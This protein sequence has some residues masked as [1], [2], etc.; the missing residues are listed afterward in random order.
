MYIQHTSYS[1]PCFNYRTITQLGIGK[2]KGG[3]NNTFEIQA[4]SCSRS[5]LRLRRQHLSLKGW[6]V[7]EDVYYMLSILTIPVV[8][9]IYYK[10]YLPNVLV[11]NNDFIYQFIRT[12]SHL[13]VF[14]VV[15]ELY[16]IKYTHND[17][18][19]KHWLHM[20]TK[21]KQLLL[22]FIIAKT[23]YFTHLLQH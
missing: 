8:W 16:L 20:R 12:T 6:L 11:H 13:M 21:H 23:A 22:S 14:L 19:Y 1:H 4:I 2:T 15:F 3:K 17:I 18:I 9:Q 7:Y 10:P 5:P